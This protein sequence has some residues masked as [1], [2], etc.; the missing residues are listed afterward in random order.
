ML[1]SHADR[2]RFVGDHAPR[3]FTARERAHGTVLVDG[4]LQAVWRLERA[5][6]GP[7]ALAVTHAAGLPRRALTAVTAEG[8]RALRFLAAG[9]PAGEVRLVRAA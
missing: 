7:V 1:L 8:R 9:A 3:L 2:A 5:D 4:M 6:D